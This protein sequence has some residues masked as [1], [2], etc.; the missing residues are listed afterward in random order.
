VTLDPGHDRATPTA[1]PETV[2]PAESQVPDNVD[3]VRS[4]EELAVARDVVEAGRIRVHKD[5]VVERERHVVGRGV[6]NATVERLSPFDDDDGEVHT[7]EDGSIS[8]PVL[9]EELVVTKRVVVRERLLIRK[10]TI[11]EEENV[12]VDLERERVRIDHDDADGN[13]V[14]GQTLAE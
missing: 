14:G 8:I 11:I 5:I 4:E 7:L 6:E 9:E 10:H 1:E 3:I 13:R 12:A 2:D